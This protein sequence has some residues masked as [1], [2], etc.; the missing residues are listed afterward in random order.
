MLVSSILHN[1]RSRFFVSTFKILTVVLYPLHHSTLVSCRTRV[2][3]T[4]VLHSN[5]QRHH[6]RRRM[7][8]SFVTRYY[9]CR[10]PIREHIGVHAHVPM[11]HIFPARSYVVWVEVPL[12]RTLVPSLKSVGR[13]SRLLCATVSR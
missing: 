7:N 3:Y 5:A 8:D 1:K 12:A 11:L 4:Y 9:Q 13:L 6:T 2:V 10:S